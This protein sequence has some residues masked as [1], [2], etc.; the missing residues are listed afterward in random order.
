MRVLW[1]TPFYS[2]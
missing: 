2:A 1:T